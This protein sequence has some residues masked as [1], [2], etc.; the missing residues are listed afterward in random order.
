MRVK[1]E[2]VA[3]NHRYRYDCRLGRCGRFR[4]CSPVRIYHRLSLCIAPE[5]KPVQELCGRS[6][7]N[8]GV[9]RQDERAGGRLRGGG[10]RLQ[11]PR[12]VARGVACLPEG[13]R[14]SLRRVQGAALPRA[15]QP[16]PRQSLKGGVPGRGGERGAAEGQGVLFVRPQRDHVHRAGRLLPPRRRAVLPRQVLVEEGVHTR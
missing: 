2:A 7:Q 11:G 9:R 10:R 1:T 15:R 14:G 6:R 8:G 13:Y 5:A 12:P 3:W 4:S 16:R